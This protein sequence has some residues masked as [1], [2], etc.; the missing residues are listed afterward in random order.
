MPVLFIGDW[1]VAGFSNDAPTAPVHMESDAVAGRFFKD[2]LTVPVIL[3]GDAASVGDYQEK[4]N[5]P[6]SIDVD[7]ASVENSKDEPTMPAPMLVMRP[8]AAQP[9]NMRTMMNA[10]KEVASS[11]TSWAAQAH[12]RCTLMIGLQKM[13]GRREGCP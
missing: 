6:G 11:Q 10:R 4:P 8:S 7:A 1:V 2:V 12:L 9:T 5:G 13:K 3:V